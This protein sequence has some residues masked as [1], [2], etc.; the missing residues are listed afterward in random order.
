MKN[1]QATKAFR[2]APVSQAVLKNAVPAMLA[3]RS[4]TETPSPVFTERE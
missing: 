4:K 3:H 2:D 1:D